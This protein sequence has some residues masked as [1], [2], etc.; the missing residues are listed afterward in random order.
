[1]SEDSGSRVLREALDAEPLVEAVRRALRR[2]GVREAWLV[3]GLPRDLSTGAAARG[4][5]RDVDVALPG[6]GEVAALEVAGLVGG[7]AFPLDEAQ[8][9]WRVACPAGDTVDLVPL[10]APDLTGDL[11]GRDFTVNALAYDLLGGAGL[12]DPLGGLADLRRRR[13]ALCSPRSLAD[14]PL[15]VLRAYRFAFGLGLDWAEGLPQALAAAATELGRVSPERVRTELFA[16][17]ALPKGAKALRALAE[18]GVLGALFPFVEVWRGFDQGDYHTHDLLEHGLRAAEEAEALAA[19]PEGAGFP[20]PEALRTH[21]AEELEAGVSRLALLKAAAFLHDVAKPETLTVEQGGR[22]RFLGHEVRGGHLLRRLLG[23][24]RVGRRARAVAQNLVAAHLRL[25]GLAHQT[26][27]TRAARLRYLRDLRGD[28]PEA[29]ML[30]IADEKATG[31]NPPA[32]PAVLRTGRE[33]LALYWE[34]RERKEI[35]PLVRGR[36]LV[37][38][39]GLPEGPAVGEILRR[40]AEAETRGHVATRGEALALAKRV[41]EGRRGG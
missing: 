13:L 31:P 9:A 4:G 10:R 7:T 22:R 40:I 21:L 8:G 28:V 2:A 39:L 14:D 6:S 15:R 17:L 25:F 24:L 16:V 38:L 1:M 27:P 35:P 20:R 32:L 37:E 34:Q 36:D 33:L 23:D 30:S 41:V 12:A 11:L 3:G 18:H 19:D 5:R 26:P 29:L